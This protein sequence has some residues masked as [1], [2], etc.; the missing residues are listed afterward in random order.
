MCTWTKDSYRRV[1]LIILW[2]VS[3][4]YGTFQVEGTLLSNECWVNESGMRNRT[5]T[6]G[7]AKIKIK[8][9]SNMPL[10]AKG[11][12]MTAAQRTFDG[13]RQ[14]SSSTRRPVSIGFSMSLGRMG[15]IWQWFS[16]TRFLCRWQLSVK[17]IQHHPVPPR[18]NAKHVK[19]K[20]SRGMLFMNPT[21]NHQTKTLRLG[22]SA[23]PWIMFDT[24]LFFQGFSKGLRIDWLVTTSDQRTCFLQS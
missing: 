22:N 21:L 4:V 2:G 10:G 14:G 20:E 15:V 9:S 5:N 8:F 6:V 16:D 23:K 3:F 24:N 1:C 13:A 7:H 19:I 11:S 12:Q 17:C 18:V